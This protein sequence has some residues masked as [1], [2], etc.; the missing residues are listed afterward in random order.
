MAIMVQLNKIKE[1]WLILVIVVVLLGAIFFIQ[2]TSIS[3]TFSMGAGYGNYGG[4][5]ESAAMATSVNMMY[6]SANAGYYPG[7]AINDNFAP[8]EQNRKITKT[9]SMNTEVE[10]NTFKKNEAKLKAVIITTNSYL[11]NENVNKQDIDKYSYYYGSYQIKVE[12]SKYSAIIAQLKDIGETK[13]F[14][15]N[16]QDITAET[17]NIEIELTAEK[18]RLAKFQELYDNAKTTQEKLEITDRIFNQERTIKYYEDALKNK[19]KQVQY[20]TIYFSMTEKQSQYRNIIFIK[21]PE[22]VK[23]LVGSMNSLLSLLFVIVPY[24]IAGLL[25]WLIIRFFRTRR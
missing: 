1:N 14:N 11:L 5:Y 6:N 25:L 9:V 3:K 24:V 18:Q 21:F 7:Q 2:P 13:S 19:D 23:K 16:A 17:K 20:S 10:Q 4:T 12:A 22:L 8:E 15:E